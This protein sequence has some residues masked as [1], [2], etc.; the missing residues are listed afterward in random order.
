VSP[1]EKLLA[2]RIVKKFSLSYWQRRY[3]PILLTK[4]SPAFT[5]PECSLPCSQ[6]PATGLYPQREQS[7][8]FTTYYKI[9]LPT[10]NQN[11]KLNLFNNLTR[12]TRL[13]L[14]LLLRELFI[15]YTRERYFGKQIA[16]NCM[17][18][19]CP[20]SSA[21]LAAVQG[22]L[23]WTVYIRRQWTLLLRRDLPLH[24]I[25]NELLTY[26]VLRYWK[27]SHRFSLAGKNKAVR[28]MI[29]RLVDEDNYV[30]CTLPKLLLGWWNWGGWTGYETCTGEL[31]ISC[32]I[33]AKT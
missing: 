7:W 6:G 4:K 17:I 33:F 29:S 2:A 13:S 28:R 3:I 5:E 14:G 12:P 19:S 11:Q 16:R 8:F 24:N 10:F 22:T 31:R 18:F 32:R 23:N 9:T 27:W 1:F 15:Y 30:Y 26:T 20:F 21:Q 25:A